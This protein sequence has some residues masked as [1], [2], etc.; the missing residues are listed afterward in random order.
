M[1]L[2]LHTCCA[3]CSGWIIQQLLAEKIELTLFFYNPN[4]HPHDEYL[5]RKLEVM[6]FAQKLAVPFVEHD[7]DTALW[8]QCIRGLEDEPERGK[9]CSICFFMRLFETAKYA[10]A[11]SFDAFTTSL[12][13][14]RFKDAKQI[15]DAG[16]RAASLN[17]IEYLQRNWRAQDGTQQANLVASTEK[18]YKQRYCGCIFATKNQIKNK[19]LPKREDIANFTSKCVDNML[20]VCNV[21]S[22]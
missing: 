3:P 22:T 12:A 20:A 1:K 21:V 7:Y 15:A 8:Y 17:N 9:R 10:A 6:K 14:S 16:L 11:N 19:N 4:V 2:L 5:R 13:M 18:F